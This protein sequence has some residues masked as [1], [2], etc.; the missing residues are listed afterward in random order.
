MSRFF[1]FF[2][3]NTIQ[4]NQGSIGK[5]LILCVTLQDIPSLTAEAAKEHPGVSYIITAP[6]G[7]HDL[8][9]V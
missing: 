4:E 1:F 2:F 5:C 3:L 9:V 6:L 8:L 7:L